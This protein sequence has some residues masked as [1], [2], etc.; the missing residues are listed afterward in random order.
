MT[1]LRPDHE[2]GERY[3]VLR[4]ISAIFIGVGAIL[5]VAGTLLLTFGLYSYLASR[6]PRHRV[7]E[8]HSPLNLLASSRT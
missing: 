7:V 3:V 5:L 6:G 1:Q 4:V 8:S 2:P